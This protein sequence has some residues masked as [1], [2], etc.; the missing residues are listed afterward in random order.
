MIFMNKGEKKIDN[1]FVKKTI[2]QKPINE[3]EK[4][5]DNNNETN[6]GLNYEKLLYLLNY[7]NLI[8]EEILNNENENE[9]N[10]R[11]HFIE[12]LDE[13][14]NTLKEEYEYKSKIEVEINEKDKIFCKNKNDYTSYL[15]LILKLSEFIMMSIS[16]IFTFSIYRN[17]KEKK[18]N[19][20]F[21]SG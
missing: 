13:I 7:Q 11:K 1:I 5:E 2:C 10:K 18:N 4:K 17:T 20:K 3:Q 21:F 9:I 14:K 12:K 15:K 19:K 6:Y 16:I 8:I